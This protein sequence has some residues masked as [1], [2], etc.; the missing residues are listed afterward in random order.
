MWTYFRGWK[1][2]IGL[3]M[4][5]MA[6]V[7]TGEWV[8]SLNTFDELGIPWGSCMHFISSSTGTLGW[9]RNSG[10]SSDD[11]LSHSF[12]TRR[13]SKSEFE[14]VFVQFQME[15]SFRW[16]GFRCGKSKLHKLQ[17]WMIPYWS[18]VFPLTLISAWCLLIRPR[19]KTVA[20]QDCNDV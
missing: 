9:W 3:M 10:F 1:R 8:R 16:D 20:M 7:L 15:W 11:Q 18:I 12:Q 14:D 2:K 17:I 5:A 19:T 13:T 4:L 6:L